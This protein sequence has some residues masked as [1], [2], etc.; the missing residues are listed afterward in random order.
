[1]LAS[2]RESCLFGRTYRLCH[3]RRHRPAS[4]RLSSTATSPPSVIVHGMVTR[5][6][7]ESALEATRPRGIWRVPAVPRLASACFLWTYGC[8]RGRGG[9]PWW[10]GGRARRAG[11]AG[12]GRRQGADVEGHEPAAGRRRGRVGAEALLA[13]ISRREYLHAKGI[14]IEAAVRVTISISKNR[15]QDK[16]AERSISRAATTKTEP[17]F[18]C[19]FVRLGTRKSSRNSL[20]ISI[21]KKENLEQDYAGDGAGREKLTG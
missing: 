4:C 17:N 8:P 3:W 2:K 20:Q 14:R 12:E 1:M 15:A 18:A 19:S 7:K 13:D 9:C 21:P 6:G 11:V 16:L 10:R 5:T